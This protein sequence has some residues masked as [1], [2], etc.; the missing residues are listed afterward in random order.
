MQSYLWVYVLIKGRVSMQILDVI[1]SPTWP[2]VKKLK[3]GWVIKPIR[4]FI[5]QSTA[6]AGYN[7]RPELC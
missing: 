6:S 1:E 7:T 4:T 5:M 3:F 2:P